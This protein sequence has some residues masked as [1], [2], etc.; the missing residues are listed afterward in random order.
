MGNVVSNCFVIYYDNGTFVTINPVI[1]IKRPMDEFL[2]P[3]ESVLVF[4][5]VFTASKYIRENCPGLEKVRV[6]A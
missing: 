3:G 2:E 6:C 4:D 1:Y 5:T